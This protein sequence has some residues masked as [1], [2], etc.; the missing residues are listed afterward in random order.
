MEL[1][2]PAGPP[3]T[4]TRRRSPWIRRRRHAR[5][6]L[7]KSKVI[8][9]CT[10]PSAAGRSLACHRRVATRAV[11]T[12]GTTR[13]RAGRRSSRKTGRCCSSSGRAPWRGY[14]DVPGGFCDPGE[15]P[16]D[17][18]KREV[19]EETGLADIELTGFL[20]AWIDTYPDPRADR[21]ERPVESTLNH[22]YL[23]RRTTADPLRPDLDEVLAARFF[24]AD[25][26][27]GEIAFPD[28]IGPVLRSWIEG[29]KVSTEVRGSAEGS[30]H[31]DVRNE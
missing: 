24:G 22:Y 12:T 31:P 11:R 14:W 3:A 27:P 4:V 29:R 1:L 18:A 28:H 17:A 7:R 9:C 8:R 19:A 6:S 21:G 5:S 16:A 26:L 15:H 23:A 2:E 13:N 10:A 25:Q 20:G 30:K